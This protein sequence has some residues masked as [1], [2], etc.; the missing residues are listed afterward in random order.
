MKWFGMEWIDSKKTFDM[1]L[2]SW[3]KKCIG[4]FGVAE[5]MPK[6]LGNSIKKWKKE[7]TSGRKKLR[8]VRIKRYIFE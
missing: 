8:T 5:N 3:L 6:V 4:M 2:N 1:V 7:L